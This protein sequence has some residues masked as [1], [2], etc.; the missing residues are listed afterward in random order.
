MHGIGLAIQHSNGV[1]RMAKHRRAKSWQPSRGKGRR[2]AHGKGVSWQSSNAGGRVAR[3]R[4]A[5]AR[6]ALAV[7]QCSV[8]ERKGGQWQPSM[9]RQ[10]T[11]TGW[12]ARHG[13]G[14]SGWRRRAPDRTATAG[15]AWQRQSST[16]L[17]RNAVDSRVMA[18]G[19]W[20]ATQSAALS[21]IAMADVRRKALQSGA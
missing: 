17:D 8:W 20:N 21:C 7:Q 14:S 12:I 3:W 15:R 11:A 6:W 4:E 13:H 10:R 9:A 19:Q 5:M 16:G 2:G 18:A 1:A